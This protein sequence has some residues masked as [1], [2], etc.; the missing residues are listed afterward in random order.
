MV[1]IIMPIRNEERFLRRCLDSVAA[2]RYPVDR[3]EVLVLDG[4]STDTSVAIATSYVNRLP[5]L[6]VLP[7]PAR[8]QSAA[9][10]L[11]LAAVVLFNRR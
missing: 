8:I 1:T 11:G 2:T 5:L 6:K 4:E 10:N 3:L 9:F 7:N